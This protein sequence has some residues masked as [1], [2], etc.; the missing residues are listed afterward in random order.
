MKRM[1]FERPTEYYDE[2]LIPID[3]L[4][5]SLL[6]QRKEISNANPGFPPLEDISEW[7]EKYGLYEELLRS[8]FGVLDNDFYF[9]PMVEPEDFQKYIPVLKTVEKEKYL[10][11]V[12]FIKQYANASVVNFNIDWEPEEN[13]DIERFHHHSFWALWIGEEY[14]CRETGGGG[15]DA[16]IS[17]NFIVSPPLPENINGLELNFKEYQTPFKKKPTGKEI[18]VHIE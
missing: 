6:Q 14:D 11:T 13:S 1:P 16:H 10:Y 8:I 2:R 5:C 3:E 12:T 18:V 4:I 7:A 15:T 9:K 17:Y